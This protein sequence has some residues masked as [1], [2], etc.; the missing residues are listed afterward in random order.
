MNVAR[1]HGACPPHRLPSPPSAHFACRAEG[2]ALLVL[3]SALRHA[4]HAL[5]RAHP[6]LAQGEDGPDGGHNKNDACTAEDLAYLILALRDTLGTYHDA[7]C[8]PLDERP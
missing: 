8:A 1:P 7:C 5:V 2:A 3:D 4:E 6:H